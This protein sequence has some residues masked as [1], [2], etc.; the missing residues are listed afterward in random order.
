MY[1]EEG[2]WYN[3][4][5]VHEVLQMRWA[6]LGKHLQDH[7]YARYAQTKQ[8]DLK[9]CRPHTEGSQLKAT[10]REE[11]KVDTD[12]PS[13]SLISRRVEANKHDFSV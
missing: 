9:G 1:M 5:G 2:V 3:R 12:F 8:E 4:R 11:G 7:S 10:G 6:E 13:M